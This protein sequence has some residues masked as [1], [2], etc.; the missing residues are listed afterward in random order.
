MSSFELTDD[1]I[2]GFYLKIISKNISISMIDGCVTKKKKKSM[3]DG[4]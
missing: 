2:V 3:I 4:Y 1:S